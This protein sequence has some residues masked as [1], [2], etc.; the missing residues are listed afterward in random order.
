MKTQIFFTATGIGSVP[1]LDIHET[2][3]HIL[4]TCPQ[5]P[6]WPQ[7]VKRSPLEDMTVQFSEGLPLIELAGDQRSLAL[8]S[9]EP[10]AELVRFYDQYLADEVDAFA[11]S[12]TYAPGLYELIDL[13][14][15]NPDPCGPFIKGQ[16]VA[17]PMMYLALSYD[18][19]L[20]DGREAVTF[21]VRIKEAIEDPT[22]LLIDL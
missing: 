17:R 4:K 12:R 15:E 22:R 3:L 6:F 14:R 7:F 11:V 1:F 9:R 19:R 18:H 5:M 13:V 10:E 2:C 16:I 21:L 20:V 8:A